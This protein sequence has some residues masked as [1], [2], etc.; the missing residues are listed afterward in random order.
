MTGRR[1]WTWLPAL[2]AG[3]WLVL[4][5]AAGAHGGGAATGARHHLEL[6]PTEVAA[7]GIDHA[8]EHAEGRL[9]AR[10]ARARW[11]RMAP[12]Q[13]RQRV[14]TAERQEKRLNRAI[15]DRPR[16]DIGFWAGDADG[17]P[18][19]LPEYAIHASMMPTGEILYFGREPLNPDRSRSNLGDAAIFNPATGESRQVTPPPIPE[20]PDDQGQPMPAAIFCAGQAILSDG[21]ILIVGGNLNDPAVTG[22]PNNAG[23]KHTFLFDPWTETWRLGPQMPIG[24]W[25]PTVT[26][27]SSGD[28]IILSGLDETGQGSTNPTMELYRPDGSIGSLTTLR[29]GYRGPSLYPGMFT[30]PNGNVAI[31]SPGAGDSAILDTAKALNPSTSQGGA[32]REIVPGPGEHYGGAAALEP[33]MGAF[34]GSWQ[35]IAMGGTP[36]LPGRQFAT[37]NVE[38]LDARPGAEKWQIPDPQEQLNEGRNYLNDVLLP[39]GGL[40][41]VG[42]GSGADTT[43]NPGDLPQNNYFITDPAPPELRQVELRRP[44]EKTWRL[45]AAQQEWRT[46][47]STA[48]LLPDGRIFSA[49]D[50]YHEGP[51]AFDPEP[52]SVRRD[53]AEIYWPPYLFNGDSCAPRPAIRAVGAT[54]PPADPDA[55]WATLTYGEAFGIFTEHARAGMQ[56]AL[57]APSQTTHSLDMNQRVV[58]LKVTKVT[59]VGGLNVLAPAAAGIA[60]PGWYMLF[61]VDADGT[62]SIAR[63]VKLV[64]AGSSELDGIPATTVTQ[65]WPNP[66]G[67]TCANPDGT[68][69]TEPPPIPPAAPPAPA[70]PAPPPPA[71][72]KL[73]AKLGVNRETIKSAARRLDV[74]AGI[75]RRASGKV[76]IE[77]LAGG[78]RT[79]FRARIDSAKGRIAVL[80]RIPRSQARL[81]TGIV[82]ITYDGDDDTRGQSVRLRAA[83]HA[84]RLKMKRPALSGAGKITAAGTIS[85]RA[86]GVVRVQLQFVHDGVTRTLHLRAKISHGAWKLHEQLP[87]GVREQIAQRTGTL[88]S[89]TLFTGYK[90]AGIR[91]EMRSFEVLGTR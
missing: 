20:N 21:R 11:K 25:Y 42:G 24:R 40:V 47:H 61:V 6:D 27:L 63:W 69:I 50:D 38:R 88:H 74:L 55:P 5:C 12:A 84:A 2:V 59:R 87:A 46:Y 15:D 10:Q 35:I 89:Y 29:G 54:A 39:D 23:L 82:T 73:T 8:R 18:F 51:D 41:V 79:S 58:P 90:R 7:L 37:R 72:T 3:V 45:G 4:V 75:T 28:F 83:R 31:A 48:S 56:A 78:H 80:H 85:R 1:T 91:G 13:R 19:V 16:D 22:N 44:G 43:H 32:W 77:L 64:P 33:Q 76:R 49:G 86:R 52:D 62:P 26:K 14:A 57:V 36:N 71:A 67:R 9:L 60:P 53:S 17:K 34:G 65:T 68:T 66:K 81:G 70:P 30:L